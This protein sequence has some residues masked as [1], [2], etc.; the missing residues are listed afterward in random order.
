VSPLEPCPKGSPP[1]ARG[2]RVLWSSAGGCL[3]ITPARAGST[4]LFLNKKD[5][6]ADHPRPRGEHAIPDLVKAV[7]EGSPPPARGAHILRY[8]RVSNDRITPA[9][10]GST[11][12]GVNSISLARDHPRPRGEHELVARMEGRNRDHPRPRGEHT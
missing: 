11:A 1:P 2:A 10:A 5:L 8:W 9:R 4:A 6:I 7:P 12:H 3:G